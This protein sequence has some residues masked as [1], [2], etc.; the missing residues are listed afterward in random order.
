MDGK[1]PLYLEELAAIFACGCN[2][3][4]C[5]HVA[6]WFHA[7]CHQEAGLDIKLADGNLE[8]Y[9]NKCK[10]YV[11]SVALAKRGEKGG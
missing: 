6:E 7:K 11:C 5:N 8:L 1:T 4:E 3:D 10:E 9:C 2:S